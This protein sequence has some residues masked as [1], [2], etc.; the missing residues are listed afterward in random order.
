MPSQHWL[1]Q[2]LAASPVT[3][4]LRI[5]QIGYWPWGRRASAGSKFSHSSLL[6]KIYPFHGNLIEDA[7]TLERV[8]LHVCMCECMILSII[9]LSLSFSHL[10]LP[11]HLSVI[12][13]PIHLC[14]PCTSILSIYIYLSYLRIYKK[15]N[16]V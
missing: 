7:E 6:A 15:G 12:Y 13:L 2:G 3:G 5:L 8:V 9:C 1:V 10:Y 4:W 11:V 16:N 14:H